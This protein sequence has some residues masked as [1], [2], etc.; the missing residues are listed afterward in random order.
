MGVRDL[1]RKRKD[2]IE[3]KFTMSDE[4]YICPG[5]I[6]F[7]NYVFSQFIYT[8]RVLASRV[9]GRLLDDDPL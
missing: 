8:Q 3:I 5:K 2:K 7:I 4:T 6:C 9:S 1:R